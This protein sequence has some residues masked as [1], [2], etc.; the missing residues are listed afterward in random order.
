MKFKGN[1]GDNAGAITVFATEKKCPGKYQIYFYVT[2]EIKTTGP[3]G[4]ALMT[5][6]DSSGAVSI[7]EK[8]TNQT[9]TMKKG[10]TVSA[11]VTIPANQEIRVLRY[12]PTI[13]MHI[14][15]KNRTSTGAIDFN[16]EVD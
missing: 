8:V 15:P 10:K 2:Y 1:F 12:D 6:A 14:E 5:V 7:R 11:I 16:V 3:Q 9:M 13:S 4:N